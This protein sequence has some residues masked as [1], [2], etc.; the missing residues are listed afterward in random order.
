M[1]STDCGSRKSQEGGKCF[2]KLDLS[3]AYLQAEVSDES[4]YLLTNN[5]P[6]GLFQYKRLPFSVKSTSVL[7][8]QL[9]DIML[10]GLSFAF[11]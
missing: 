5:T 2:A 4:K 1:G 11:A 9:M 7:F 10:Q 6:R 8:E 3:D